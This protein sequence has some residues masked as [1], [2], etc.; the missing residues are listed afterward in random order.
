MGEVEFDANLKTSGNGPIEQKYVG[1]PLKTIIENAGVK[2]D[3]NSVA[4]VS[5]IDG[6][7]VALTMDKLLDEGN[8][9]LAYICEGELIGTKAEGGKGPYQMVISKDPFSQFWCKYAYNVD[10]VTK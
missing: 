2:L 3:E 7:S 5:A 1:V 10:V 8:V 6:Y 4:V 9:Y